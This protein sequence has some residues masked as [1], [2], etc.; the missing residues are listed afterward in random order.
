MEIETMIHSSLEQRIQ[1]GM[2]ENSKIGESSLVTMKNVF[3]DVAAD[4]IL[5]TGHEEDLVDDF[6]FL[7]D[8]LEECT[9]FTVIGKVKMYGSYIK[10]MSQ[11]YNNYIPNFLDQTKKRLVVEAIPNFTNQ[12][13]SWQLK[14]EE[15]DIIF[16]YGYD[17]T[18]PGKEAA[19]ALFHY[20]DSNF[21]KKST[22]SKIKK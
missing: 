17:V 9:D 3:F 1:K 2:M 16:T 19:V 7:L 13:T 22:P 21:I 15:N 12:A 20:I 5:L 11:I 6:G 10:M 8:Y 18:H 4:N 14:E